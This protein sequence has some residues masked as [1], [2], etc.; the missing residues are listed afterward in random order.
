[1]RSTVDAVCIICG[2][3][4]KWDTMCPRMCSP[5]L[6]HVTR[7]VGQQPIRM[8]DLAPPDKSNKEKRP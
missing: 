1:M 6:T 7:P 4:I 8:H 3:D 5:C 2:Q